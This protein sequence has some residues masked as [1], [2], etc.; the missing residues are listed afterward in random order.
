MGWEA[1]RRAILSFR[2]IRRAEFLFV[3]NEIDGV[4]KPH[5]S[6]R[7]LDRNDFGLRCSI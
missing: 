2:G 6:N 5:R 3:A 7:I 4:V 1:V